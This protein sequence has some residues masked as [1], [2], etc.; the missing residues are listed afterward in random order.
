LDRA[1]LGAFADLVRGNGSGPVADLGC[2]PGRITA[3]LDAL[4]LDAVG[5]DL[6]PRMIELA[7]QAYPNVRFG[8]GSL[9]ELAFADGVLAGVV[10][11]YSIIHLPPERVPDV[12]AEFYRVLRKGGHAL[13]AFQATDLPEA[14][15]FD[16]KVIRSYRWSPQRLGTVAEQAGFATLA[17]MVREPDADERGQQ[18]YLLVVKDHSDSSTD[19]HRV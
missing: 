1:M 13:L 16:H 6:S 9:E 7:R 19:D 4:G 5:I 15:P 17:R 3:H 11:W 18:G 8:E 10:A 14:E 2:G 12:L